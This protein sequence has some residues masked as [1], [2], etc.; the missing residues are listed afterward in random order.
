MINFNQLRAF[1]EVAKL[2]N[3]REASKILCVTQPAVSNQV[4]AFEEFCGLNLFKRQGKRLI[5]TDMGRILLKQCHTL[6][7]L[8]KNIEKDIKSL[9]NLQIGILKVGASKAFVQYLISPY[10]EKFHTSY[11]N[12]TFIL[13]E[14]D[15]REIGMSILRF[16][17]ELGIIAK[18]PDMNGIESEPI[19]NW[20]IV[21]FA[22]PDHPLAKKKRGIHFKELEGEPIIMNG[23][24]SGTRHVVN[25]AFSRHG[26]VPNT[27]LETSNIDVIMQM[28][29][30][31][32]CISLLTEGAVTRGAKDKPMQ[33][34][35]I[36]DEKLNLEVVVTF[37][38]DQP[39]SPAAK[40]FL[41]IL[42]ENTEVN[43]P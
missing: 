33:I 37:L 21:L 8:E 35:P 25:Q 29:N 1:Y 34:I 7:D 12:I 36:I 2:E 30:Q 39:L 9:H 32:E 5:I 43:E 20:E 22:S 18:L 4:K 23:K 41:K 27:L 42:K 28:V 31:G 26:I 3:V 19:S 16:E 15:S 6:F 17:N 14:G 24:G 13:H 38:K 40:A 10:L 11:P